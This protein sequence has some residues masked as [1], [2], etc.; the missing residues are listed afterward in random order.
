MHS[1]GGYKGSGS[2]SGGRVN[3]L[4]VSKRAMENQTGPAAAQGPGYQSSKV[5]T[6]LL[7][8]SYNKHKLICSPS[9]LKNQTLCDLCVLFPP[10]G[11]SNDQA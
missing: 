5:E 3:Q 11:G 1:E 6:Q 8:F 10:A 4:P 9:V 2:G 7:F